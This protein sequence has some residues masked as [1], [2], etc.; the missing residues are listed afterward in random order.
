MNTSTIRCDCCLGSMQQLVPYGKYRHLT[1]TV[2]GHE[3]FLRQEETISAKLY[4][5]DAD[6]NADLAI[7]KSHKDMLQW[8]HIQAIPQIEA[9]A[10][11]KAPRV[12]DIGCFNGFFVKELRDRGFDA[13]GIDFN[14]K[15]LAFGQTIY[16]LEGHITARTLADLN[17]HGERFDVITMFEVVEHLED[18]ASVIGQALSLL[19]PDGV[20]IMSTPNSRMSWR[21]ELDTPPHHLSRFTPTSMRRLMETHGLKVLFQAEQTSSFD[22]IRNYLGSLL[23]RKAVQSMRGGEFRNQLTANR[24]RTIA[25]RTKWVVYRLATPIDALL[26]MLG[27]RYISQIIV[28]QKLS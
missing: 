19:R 6:Y 23:R 17:Q 21:P 1:C 8:N 9:I 27:I 18:F 15:A 16:Q 4:E 7:A 22:L 5:D 28:A 3:R 14:R 2:C 20:M 10:K 26:Y 11:I 13:S 25:N 12:L 24:L